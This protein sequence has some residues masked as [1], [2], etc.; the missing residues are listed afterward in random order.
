MHVLYAAGCVQLVDC[1]H[2]ACRLEDNHKCL[3][4]GVLLN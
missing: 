1:A 4:V 2:C 3:V